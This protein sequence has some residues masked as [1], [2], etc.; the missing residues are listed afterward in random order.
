MQGAGMTGLGLPQAQ[1]LPGFNGLTAT[2]VQQET[3][4]LIDCG[5]SAWSHF[6]PTE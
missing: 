1:H 5:I 3:A 4:F 6:H 2:V